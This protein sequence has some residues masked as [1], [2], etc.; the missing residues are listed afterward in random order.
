MTEEALFHAA[1]AKPP[2][3]RAA[4]L[5]EVCSRNA[6]LR[7]AVEAS[8]AAHDALSCFPNVLRANQSDG[9]L[10]AM[11]DSGFVDE[12]AATGEHIP[13]PGDLQDS[14]AP[15]AVTADYRREAAAGVV[16]GGRYTLQEKIG[17]GGMGEVWVAKQTAPVKRKVALKLIKT[18]MDSRAVLQRFEQERQALALMDHPHIARVLDGGLTPTGQPFFVME[19]VNGLSL[20][21]FCDE[22]KLALPARLEL[23]VPICQ[24]VQHAHQKGIVHRDL[25]PANILVTMI[26]GKP[27]PK[28]IDFGVAKATSGKLTEET[29]STG[30]GAVVGTLEY[31]APE[32]AGYSGEDIDT[33]ADIYSLGV[34]LYELLT[35]LRPIDANR[36]RKA[37]IT[38][39]IRIIQE[40][41]PSKPSM[42]L[43]TNDSLL[44][45]A[46]LRQTEPNKLTA[47]LRGELDWVVMKCLEKQRDR[48]YETANAL[49]RDV[50]RYLANEV[51]EARPPSA[52]YRLQ[53]FV[54]RNRG[55]VVAVSLLLLA[56]VGGVVGTTIGLVQADTARRAEAKRAE[57]ERRAKLD[58]ELARDQARERYL[59]ALSAFDDM[60]FAIQNKLA[61]RP[62][63]LELRKDLLT[64][65]R[66]GLKKLLA[67]S[68]RHGN[69][70]K[71]LVWS[72]FQMGTIERLLGNLEAAREEF[73]TGHDK[74][75]LLADAAPGNADAQRDVG[76]GLSH[77]GDIALQLK[78]SEQALAYFLAKFEI[79]RRLAAAE[80]ANMDLQRDLSV[81]C[82][83]L[84]AVSLQLGRTE[85][86]HGYHKQRLQISQ[87]IAA[88]DPTNTVSQRDLAVSYELLGNSAGYLNQPALV[89]D[90]YQKL[91]EIMQDLL[92]IDPENTV[93]QRDV[94][95]GLLKLGNLNQ[96]AGQL[97]A[98]L[99]YY[100]RAIVILQ[101][102]AAADPQ[103]I[104]NQMDLFVGYDNLAVTEESRHE[105]GRAADWYR[106][107]R[108]VI[109][110]WHNKK[111]LVGQFEGALETVD[112]R[113]AECESNLDNA[114]TPEAGPVKEVGDK[115]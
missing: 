18:G 101:K 43:S 6:P 112:Q 49:S 71:K 111:L 95:V 80:P 29:M 41:E 14:R 81:S 86:A 1:L 114:L 96:D 103:N 105:F 11:L 59:L 22:M 16:I 110:P 9:G 15:Q 26:D 109:L 98:A 2:A 65:A 5:D 40:E 53:K 74:A 62:G 102:L 66:G 37:A 70:D 44:P 90:C 21:K 89:L 60:I 51:V 78:Q 57:G 19:L 76:V 54:R 106:K 20:T 88:A 46:A 92:D 67:E 17:E 47:L 64:G 107:G 97:E 23:F 87:T 85:E 77:L 24:A 48:R 4:F 3:E 83:Q 25:K 108:A 34:I 8:L 84:G 104:K 72:Y 28:V 10:A 69:P 33:R 100:E 38:E 73:Q 39:M 27:V 58:A 35:G 50:Q 52:S 42:R 115:H 56:L 45:L 13:D 63:T 99:D 79:D 91:N 61:S 12:S 30:F 32:Q 93:R 82:G 7:A 94:S 55:Q 36:L 68:E 31:M 75:K 113:I